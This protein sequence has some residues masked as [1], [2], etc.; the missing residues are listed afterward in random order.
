ME[1]IDIGVRNNLKVPVRLT[2]TNNGRI[3]ITIG[4]EGVTLKDYYR[5]CVDADIS[6]NKEWQEV[7]SLYIDTKSEVSFEGTTLSKI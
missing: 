6:P 4:E 3:L 2:L 1:K 7:G 5:V